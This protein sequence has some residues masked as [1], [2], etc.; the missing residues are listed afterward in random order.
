MLEV[1]SRLEGSELVLE[2]RGVLD[3][4]TIG[5]FN[6]R[7]A[8]WP[9]D[10]AAVR[11]DFS[12]LEFTDSTGI[13]AVIGTIHAAAGCGASVRFVGM[14]EPIEEM[15]ETVGVFEILKTLQKGV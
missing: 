2:L 13:G 7:T 6:E 15:F 3:F 11:I 8:D 12:R 5:I 14:S 1:F 10:V 4:A 9:S